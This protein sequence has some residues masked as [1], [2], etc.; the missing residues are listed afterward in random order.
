MATPG[1]NDG[2]NPYDDERLVTTRDLVE[3][4]GLSHQTQLN[5]MADPNRRHLMPPGGFKRPGGREWLWKLGGVLRWRDGG[6]R[7]EPPVPPPHPPSPRRSA[8]RPKGSLNKRRRI[9]Q[10][11]A[12]KAKLR[13]GGA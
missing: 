2:N 5:Y 7:V 12:G 4:I 6:K 8:S 9:Q 11:E 13:Q 3:I 1:D 10:I